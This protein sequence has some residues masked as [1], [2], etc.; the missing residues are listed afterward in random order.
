MKHP[1]RNRRQGRAGM[2]RHPFVTTAVLALAASHAGAVVLNPRGTGQVLLYPYYTA[3]A[4]LAT[5]LSIVNTTTRGKALKVRF[6]EGYNGR[7]VDSFNLYLSPNDTWVGEIFDS[8]GDGTGAAAVATGDNSCVVPAFV[9]SIDPGGRPP[10]VIFSDANYTGAN[11]DGGPVT[12]VRTLEGYID[13][14][15][16]GEVTNAAHGTLDAIT[17]DA[18]GVPARCTQVQAAWS[19]PGGYWGQNAL[20]DLAPPGGGLYGTE[21][22]I[23]VGEGLMYTI[24]ATAIDG[25]S[26]AVQH[27]GP[28][29]AAP[30][31]DTASKGADGTVAAFV[32]SGG[33]LIEAD[34]AKSEDAISALF[35][36]DNLYNEYVVDPGVGAQSD[37]VITFPTKRFYTDKALGRANAM[38]AAAPFDVAFSSADG[39]TSCTPIREQLLNREELTTVGCWWAF[40]S[41]TPPT[42]LCYATSPLT[43][44]AANSTLRSHLLIK[45]TSEVDVSG[46]GFTSGWLRID[47]SVD[48]TGATQTNHA[49]TSLNGVTLPGLPALGFLA[50]DYV[51]GNVAPGM[52]ANYSGAY[53]H[54]AHVSCL[55]ASDGSP[56]R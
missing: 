46:V 34:F 38:Q 16:M 30:D 43:I 13:V 31:L 4:G 14:I 32:A 35:M 55:D 48:I 50:V 44:G 22:I 7:V 27:T 42:A 18:N 15:E 29:D 47:F 11:A 26:D 25:F 21:S 1:H 28:G 51:N 5:L 2:K 56:C 54:R 39:G 17:H 19:A 40:C 52:L 8:S 37:W 24:N 49:L 10:Q 3:N 6:H 23:N 53:P 12:P 20:T 9:Q 45:D 33:K 36:V 41:P